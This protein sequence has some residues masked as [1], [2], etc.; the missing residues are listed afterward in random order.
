[1]S[2]NDEAIPQKS[3]VQIP[4]GLPYLGKE[5]GLEIKVK[6]AE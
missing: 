6:V 1:M 5:L 3:V 2:K 4:P